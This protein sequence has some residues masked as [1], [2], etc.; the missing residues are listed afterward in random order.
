MTVRLYAQRKAWPLTRVRVRVTHHRGTLQGR[1]SFRREITLEGPL[2][3]TQRTRLMEIAQR[4]PVHLTLERGSDVS[5]S[6]VPPDVSRGDG[7]PSGEHM[8]TMEEA[9]ER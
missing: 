7:T 5:S 9:C 8:K 2:D 6:L 4:C 3:E 1:D